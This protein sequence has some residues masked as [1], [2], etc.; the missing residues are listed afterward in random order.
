MDTPRLTTST[1]SAL[2]PNGESDIVGLYSL[3]TPRYGESR[4]ISP[5]LRTKNSIPH[6]DRSV[7]EF[8]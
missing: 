6:K 3:G 4:T 2:H 8:K 7:S 1:S 5:R